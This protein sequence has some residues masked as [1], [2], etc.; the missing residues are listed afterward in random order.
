M[1]AAPRFVIRCWGARGTFP[2]PGVQTL[3]YGGNTACLE[4]SPANGQRIVFDAGS[5]AR[6]L[7]AAMLERE[8]LHSEPSA[9]GIQVFLTHRH[10]D[11]VI[12]LPQFLPSLVERAPI[13]LRCGN[14]SVREVHELV[15]TLLAPPL[16]VVI[17]SFGEALQVEPCEVDVPIA[18]GV[19]CTVHRFDA[20][21][22]GGAA[23]FRVDDDAGPAF[24]FAPDNELSY[25]L[26]DREVVAWRLQLAQQLH[27]IPALMHD[28]TYTNSELPLFEGWGYSSA[29]EATRFA[30]E[31]EAGHL[32]L[33]HHHPNRT[34]N[35]I[36]ASV[37]KCRAIVR[38]NGSALCV[39]AAYEG[40]TI[41]I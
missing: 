9:E 4:I 41:A 5:G 26:D 13:V 8:R 20:R 10:F 25:A 32:Y 15:N 34:D 39:D 1:E 33:F 22:N 37:A 30:M 28:A 21:H 29:E 40:M 38:A 27:R 24:A 7:A 35:D 36:D 3:R 12:G 31:C 14:A 2:S 23:I 16:F 18:V 11:H 19:G 17:P 6:V